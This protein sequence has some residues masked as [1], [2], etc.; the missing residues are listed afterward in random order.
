MRF[1]ASALLFLGTFGSFALAK[2]ENARLN[3]NNS[4]LLVVDHQIGLFNVVRDATPEE[5]RNNMIAHAAIGKLVNLPTILT[6]SGQAG[7]NG[8]LPH[9]I[10]EMHPNAPLIKRAG[11]INAWDS[12][13]FRAAVKA[14]GKSQVILAAI[15]TD[16]C[17]TLLALSLVEEG[18]TVFH[19][20]E[21]SG[22]ASERIAFNANN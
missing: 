5:F 15:T 13:E 10:P 6:T 1:P 8:P 4:M 16:V 17:A 2:F 7:P 21:A 19:N 20:A 22:A 12:P 11:P 18:Y 9:E 14:T 3:K